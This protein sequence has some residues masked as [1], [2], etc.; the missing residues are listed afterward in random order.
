MTPEGGLRRYHEV[1]IAGTL[2]QV[3]GGDVLHN[4]LICDI[5]GRRGKIPA[6]PQMATPELFG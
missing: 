6:C 2:F 1:A 4:H 3:L 5:A